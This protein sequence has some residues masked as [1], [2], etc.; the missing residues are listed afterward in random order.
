MLQEQH[1]TREREILKK[2]LIFKCL[3][4]NLNIVKIKYKSNI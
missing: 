4:H 2:L 3:F 1:I